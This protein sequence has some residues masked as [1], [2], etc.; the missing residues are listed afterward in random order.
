V[1]L[2][3]LLL[4]ELCE[5]KIDWDQVMMDSWNSLTSSLQYTPSISIPRCYLEGISTEIISCTFCGFCDTS[6]KAGVVYLLLETTVGFSVKFV[7]A[8]TR[9]T[10][11]QPQTIRRLELLS[12]LLLARLLY[13]IT[14]SLE[15]E[16]TLTSPYCFTDSMVS[17]WW[18]KESD[19][20]WKIKSEG[21]QKKVWICLFTCCVV[22]AVHLELVM[23]MTTPLFQAFCRKERTSQADGQ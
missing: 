3:K 22:R 15:C 9:V 16:L 8:K 4:R 7:A 17:L 20:T 18:I 21:G 1:I 19:K 6:I 13:T 14:E 10:L 11:L 23:D 2:F 12:A 5:A